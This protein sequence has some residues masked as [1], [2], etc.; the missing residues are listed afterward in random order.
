MFKICQNF[1]VFLLL[2]FVY[3]DMPT[4]WDTDG[5]GSFDHITDFQNS[6][7][8]TS[9]VF[10][11][12]VNAGS[13]GDALAAFVNG[14]QRGFQGN[15]GVPFGPYSGTEMFPILIY[16]NASSGETVT[17]QFYDAEIDL[18]YT[19][20]ETVDFESDMTLGSFVSPEILN[21][22][23]SNGS[24]GG[25]DGDD[26]EIDSGYPSEWDTDD[27]GAFDNITDFLNS[28]S[29][30]SQITLNDYDVGS[31]G[32]MLAAFVDDELRG[33]APHYE[34]TFG[35]NQGKYFFLILIYSNVSE[36]ET[37]TFKFYDAEAD[38][39]YNI[40]ETYTYV[41]DDTQGNLFTP[42]IYTI[43]TSGSTGGDDG[44]CEDED[45]DGVC[46]DVD[47]CVGEVDCAGF[48]NGP[49]LEDCL[50]ECG[51]T[52]EIDCNGVCDGSAVEDCAGICG[53]DAVVDCAGVCGGDAI[54]D[55]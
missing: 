28:A 37:V 19:I 38:L 45:L 40:N 46:D 49:V 35:P 54:V 36:G 17:F 1:V 14:E 48:C 16:S 27:D 31:S 50:G 21:T 30:T 5:D 51:G 22:G 25:D 44:S 29:L 20:I 41:S 24:D 18:V 11:E 15:F 55:C 39:V 6:G 2:S 9:A 4:S 52:A 3:T 26:G 47:D 12:G 34:V 33:L 13:Q 23:D 32:D 7:S 8:I 42:I 43:D 10:L 53:G